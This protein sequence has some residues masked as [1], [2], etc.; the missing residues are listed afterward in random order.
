MTGR[1]VRVERADVERALGRAVSSYDVEPIDPH[2]RIHSITGGVLRIRTDVGSCVVKI[3]RRAP[4]ATPDGLWGGDDQVDGRNYWKRE[5]LAYDS[6]LLD[7][8][9]G[10]LRAPRSL[11][12]TEPSADECWIWMQ[13]VVGRTGASLRLDDFSRIAYAAG[14]TQ[15]A[16]AGGG[17]LPDQPWLSRRWLHGW[18]RACEPFVQQTRDDQGW[19]D[20]RLAAGRPLRPRILALWEA[21]EALLAIADSAPTTLTHWDFWPSNLYVDPAGDV[22]AVDWSQVGLSGV[23]HDL[24]QLTLDTVWMQVRP[25]ESLD[26]LEESVLPAYVRGLH[27]GGCDVSLA[28][29]RGW[30]AAAAALRYAWLAGGQ[31]VALADADFVAAQERRFGRPYDSVLAAKLRVCERAVLLGEA[32]LGSAL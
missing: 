5:W 19:D 15:G 6:G 20:P 18:V 28:Q 4:G 21:R 1:E 3:V 32:A 27:D 22:V 14:T 2:L 11:L 8:L 10:L 25:D 24:D 13:D 29:L 31:T 30:Y 26:A 23:T 7:G 9:P 16:Y 12:T 17:P